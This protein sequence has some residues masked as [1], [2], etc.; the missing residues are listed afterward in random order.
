MAGT[1]IEAI[2]SQIEKDFVELSK[3]AARSAANKAQK[4]IQNKADKFVEE[5]YASYRPHIYK[6]QNALYKL[7]TPYYKEKETGNGIR[8]EFGVKYNASKIKGIHK[9]G[10]WWHQS[11]G[12]W[13]SRD[14]PSFNFDKGDNGIPEPEWITDQFLSGIH[15]WAQTDAQSPDEKMQ[16][17]F[18]T[19]LDDMVSGYIGKA[20]LDAVSSYF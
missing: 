13:V 1:N 2:F 9:S 12:K 7:I 4:D 20:L 19:K 5:Y 3:N 18:D 16:D 6:R 15:P 14:D 10:S 8:I 17:F 11:G